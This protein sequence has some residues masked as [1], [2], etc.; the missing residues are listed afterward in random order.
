M[1]LTLFVKKRVYSSR[2]CSVLEWSP[3]KPT[4]VLVASDDDR[5]PTVH[6]W[7]L[8][9]SGSPLS[10]LAGH[11]KGILSMSWSPHDPRLLLTCAKD[12]KTY[13]WNVQTSQ[14]VAELPPLGAW[15]LHVQV[16]NPLFCQDFE[17]HDV[18]GL[19]SHLASSRFLRSMA[20]LA[21]AVSAP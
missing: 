6:V 5:T 1:P 15:H 14:I 3:E 2:R 11:S 19:P 20:K 8:R 4:Q 18:S 16:R 10:E 12:S 13:C 7:D 17:S 9:N 21:F